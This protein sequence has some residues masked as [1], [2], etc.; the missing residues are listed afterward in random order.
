MLNSTMLLQFLLEEEIKSE[1]VF[2]RPSYDSLIFL[3][4]IVVGGM[5]NGMANCWKYMQKFE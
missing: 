3:K 5:Y 4:A 2:Q 1:K